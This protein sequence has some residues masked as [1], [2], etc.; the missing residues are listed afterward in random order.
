MADVITID[1]NAKPAIDGFEAL[2]DEIVKTDKATDQLEASGQKAVSSFNRVRSQATAT[3]PALNQMQERLSQLGVQFSTG[4]EKAA[5]FVPQLL[6]LGPAGI[7]AVAAVGG[8]AASLAILNNTGLR[9]GKSNLDRLGTSFGDLAKTVLP[10]IDVIGK[11]DEVVTGISDTIIFNTEVLTKNAREWVAWLKGVKD[12]T[13]TDKFFER[14]QAGFAKLREE[15]KKYADAAKARGEA[16][17]V[18]GIKTVEEVKQRI[19]WLR[20]EASQIVLNTRDE[21]ERDAKL[22][23]VGQRRQALEARL[24]EV[25]KETAQAR[26]AAVKYWADQRIAAEQRVA[27]SYKEQRQKEAKAYE[28]SIEFQKRVAKDW[29][30]YQKG[31]AS[32]RRQGLLSDAEAIVRARRDEEVALAERLEGAQKEAAIKKANSELDDSLHVIRI[33]RIKEE[34]NDRLGATKV[35]A[36]EEEIRLHN[37]TENESRLNTQT[38][39]AFKDRQDDLQKQLRDAQQE[40]AKIV[41]DTDRKLAVAEAD[42]KRQQLTRQIQDRTAAAAKQ[43]ELEKQKKEALDRL[44]KG[45]GTSSGEGI[46]A[47]AILK[48]QRPQDVRKQL[49]DRA[50]AEARQRFRFENR[51]LDRRA[52]SSD[53]AREE[54]KRGQNK[55][56][57][58]AAK[59][60]SQDFA[61]G[62][63]DP[64]RLA[65]AEVDAANKTAQA[66]V[67]RGDLDKSVAQALANQLQIAAQQ[68]AK[69]EQLDREL[70]ALKDGQDAL[71]GASN[72]GRG[73]S[74]GQR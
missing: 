11:A 53:D 8:I 19:Q 45:E 57:A 70:K 37:Q 47:Q 34:M 72:P 17:E 41:L 64:A 1:L 44:A 23:E 67:Q 14:T 42:F 61:K 73:R 63:T 69:Q 28:E 21:K 65:Q 25:E 9:D 36:L 18:A 22:Q 24:L 68:Q 49:M 3:N 62:K 31:L 50:A 5:G 12:T 7:T 26:A 33:K 46:D 51:D 6:R 71:I 32:D 10:S 74:N 40:A 16:A 27:A 56:A 2:I 30:D 20:E 35:A 52:E 60:A 58:E 15:E 59:Q 13:E 55:A 48:A 43:I 39:K 38:R 4:S 54:L 66:L 29:A